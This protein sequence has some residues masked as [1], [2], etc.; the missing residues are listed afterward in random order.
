MHRHH[1]RCQRRQ[2]RAALVAG[3]RPHTDDQAGVDSGDEHGQRAVQ[4]GFAE[5]D[6]D[7]IE[8][9]LQDRDGD[10]RP[11]AQKRQ[12]LKHIH[13][14]RVRPG[15]C[16]KHHGQHQRGRRAPLQLQPLLTR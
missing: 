1:R 13:D 2:Q 16:D 7:V 4:D 12:A 6:V 10:G 15:R 3:Q 11:Q 14:R 5:H 9:V 8:P